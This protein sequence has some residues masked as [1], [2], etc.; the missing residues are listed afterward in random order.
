[1]CSLR[2]E[3]SAVRLNNPF[4]PISFS[5]LP[6][7]LMYVVF[8]YLD[9]CLT[10][11][12]KSVVKWRWPWKTWTRKLALQGQHCRQQPRDSKAIQP[13]SALGKNL[14]VFWISHVAFPIWITHVHQRDSPSE[15][16]SENYTQAKASQ[17]AME[18]TNQDGVQ[19]RPFPSLSCSHLM[20]SLQLS[21]EIHIFL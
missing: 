9:D 15:G 19:L 18:G 13:S 7:S 11:L 10:I 14:G 5:L 3:D 20:L 21:E 17:N 12:R 4:A 1:M 2:E 6:L 16:C 8:L